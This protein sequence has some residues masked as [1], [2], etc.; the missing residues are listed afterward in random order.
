LDKATGRKIIPLVA[1]A[2]ILL[3]AGVGLST[4]DGLSSYDY[5]MHSRNWAECSTWLWEEIPKTLG[6]VVL[7]VAA[8]IYNERRA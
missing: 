6:I 4:H 1:I 7:A 5:C 3:L 8:W 2:L